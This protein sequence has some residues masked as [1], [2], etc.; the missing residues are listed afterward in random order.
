MILSI[1]WE[2]DKKNYQLSNPMGNIA[3]KVSK[4]VFSPKWYIKNIIL[5][6]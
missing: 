4:Y 3:S 5:K 1:N 6:K 2:T